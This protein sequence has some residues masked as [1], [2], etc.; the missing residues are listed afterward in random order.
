MQ[1]LNVDEKEKIMKMMK[2]LLFCMTIFGSFMLSGQQMNPDLYPEALSNPRQIQQV[3]S[4]D[5][6][7]RRR[8]CC[9]PLKVPGLRKKCRCPT[10]ATGATGSTG[11][12]GP[13][14]PA[15]TS[16]VSAYGSFSLSSP[17]GFG[18]VSGVTAIN[19]P[20]AAGPI[21]SQALP[22]G[23]SS[24]GLGTIT[25]ANGGV[26]LTSF[27]VVGETDTGTS[28]EA[29]LLVNGAGEGSMKSEATAP[30]NSP[31]TASAQSILRFGNNSLLN[32]SVIN[33]CDLSTLTIEEATINLVEIA[34]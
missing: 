29:I 10:G 30:Q 4:F 28:W 31:Q 32:V 25:I 14:G 16:V 15:G 6:A 23:V 17:T 18:P 20:F 12:I 3:R 33:P 13:T 26:Y 1:Q 8:G 22:T 19:I 24:D 5:A 21:G 11:P 34:P 9:K 7:Q 2:Y 27:S